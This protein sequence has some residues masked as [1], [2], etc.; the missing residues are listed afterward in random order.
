MIGQ[1]TQ[2]F[3]G[4]NIKTLKER[5][6]KLIIIIIIQRTVI[7]IKNKYIKEENLLVVIVVVVVAVEV[8]QYKKSFLSNQVKNIKQIIKI[9]KI[10][11][12][13]IKNP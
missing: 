12:K 10:I 7:I 5:K 13:K 3:K 1:I 4:I 9:N 8:V 6:E 2:K 11:T